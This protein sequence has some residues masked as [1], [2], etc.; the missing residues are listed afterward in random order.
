MALTLVVL[1]VV[2]SLGAI[3]F[4]VVDDCKNSKLEAKVKETVS[5]LAEPPIKVEWGR[6]DSTPDGLTVSARLVP[7][8]AVPLGPVSISVEITDSGPATLLRVEPPA[9]FDVRS[10]TSSDGRLAELTFTPS[11]PGPQVIDLVLS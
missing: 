4:V 9:S 2:V 3:A 6:T 8:N 7:S 1:Q 10:S 11:M 5:K